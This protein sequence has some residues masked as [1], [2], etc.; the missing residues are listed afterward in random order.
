MFGCSGLH[1]FLF[2]GV[3]S[4]SQLWL[5]SPASG[6]KRLAAKQA[7]G[8]GHQAALALVPVTVMASEMIPS[9]STLILAMFG[10]RTTPCKNITHFLHLVQR[11]QHVA[12]ATHANQV[13]STSVIL[14]ENIGTRMVP[15]GVIESGILHLC[16]FGR[17]KHLAVLLKDVA[18]L[19]VLALESNQ[20]PLKVKPAELARP[21]SQHP[22]MSGFQDRPSCYSCSGVRFQRLFEDPL[23][24]TM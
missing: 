4:L 1:C 12:S 13:Q 19:D 7:V 10:S 14:E 8:R 23:T 16:D 22:K 18:G 11:L 20:Q 5:G 24:R 9:F 17:V 21:A 15:L 2:T 3:A 6:F